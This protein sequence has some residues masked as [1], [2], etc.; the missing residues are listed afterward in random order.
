MNLNRFTG[1]QHEQCRPD[2]DQ[3]VTILE[4]NIDGRKFKFK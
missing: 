4:E 3:H 1:L 2:R